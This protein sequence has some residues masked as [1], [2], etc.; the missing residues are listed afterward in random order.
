MAPE[1]IT[2]DYIYRRIRHEI[3]GGAFSPGTMLK[4]TRLTDRFGASAT[5][6]RDA[7]NR[8]VGER[9]VVLLP[10]GG[11][12]VRPLD[13]HRLA[14]LYRW[15]GHL[16]Q[17]ALDHPLPES[18]REGLGALKHEALE[19]GQVA[20]ASQ[21]IFGILASVPQNEE[22][23]QA[24]A[25]VSRALARARALEHR[26]L[27]DVVGE[28]WQLLATIDRKPIG[29][30]RRAMARYHRERAQSSFPICKMIE[31]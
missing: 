28:F 15:H 29:A 9:L 23:E 11:F 21:R 27:P 3:V 2:A 18:A 31:P 20:A 7:L 16:I 1:P 24:V 12:R 5:P 26:L 14:G 6:V 17:I 19:P 13:A 10:G 22:L 8:L 25:A 4:L 30:A